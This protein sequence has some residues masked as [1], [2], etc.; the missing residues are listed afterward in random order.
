ML[1]ASNFSFACSIRVSKD[2]NF[3]RFLSVLAV[4]FLTDSNSSASASF[5]ET[6]LSYASLARLYE[7]SSSDNSFRS[8]PTFSSATLYLGDFWASSRILNTSRNVPSGVLEY[9]AAD[10][11]NCPAEVIFSVRNLPHAIILEGSPVSACSRLYDSR[12]P[13][14]VSK[15]CP[16]KSCLVGS[17]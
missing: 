15:S 16:L 14:A 2:S 12:I 1:A 10:W 17:S 4:S 3:F 11:T 9:L 6:A 7:V 5:S 8:F 13:I